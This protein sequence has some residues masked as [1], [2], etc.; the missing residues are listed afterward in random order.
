MILVFFA[1]LRADDHSHPPGAVVGRASTSGAGRD[2][3]GTAKALGAIG[4][5]IFVG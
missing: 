3:A 2:G 5:R 1:A 4:S